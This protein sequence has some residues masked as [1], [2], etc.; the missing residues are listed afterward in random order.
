MLEGALRELSIGDT[1]ALAVDVG[2]V[3]DE[4]ARPASSAHR[5]DAAR[6]AA[7]VQHAGA[8]RRRAR[9]ASCC[10]R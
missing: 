10:R 2:P 4:E 1:R 3:I 6:A 5:G 9:A 7:R 8:A